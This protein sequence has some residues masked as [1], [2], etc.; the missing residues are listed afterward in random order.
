MSEVWGHIRSHECTQR[1]LKRVSEPKP[2]FPDAQEKK[3]TRGGRGRRSEGSEVKT[4]VESDTCS[5]LN[6]TCQACATSSA[7]A[8][9]LP[10][11]TFFLL[12]R[13][14]STRANPGGGPNCGTSRSSTFIQRS[15][16]LPPT[17]LFSSLPGPSPPLF[18]TARCCS[19]SLIST[20]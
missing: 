5:N 6:I 11:C 10:R 20:R 4:E 19:C 18:T 9:I 3:K 15:T 1:A 2:A 17:S 8:R 13:K 7:S 12:S 14:K 16:I